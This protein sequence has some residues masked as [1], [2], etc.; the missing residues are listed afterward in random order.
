[1][2][3]TGCCPVFGDAATTLG[4]ARAQAGSAVRYRTMFRLATAEVHAVEVLA[5]CHDD[6]K[7]TDDRI[8]D[9]VCRQA[10]DWARTG[11]RPHITV[12]LSPRQ[13]GNPRFRDELR[14]RPEH[15]LLRPSGF[16]V[17]VAASALGSA[18]PGVHAAIRLL[19][20]DGLRI[21]I[22]LGAGDV[23]PSSLAVLR[24][25][26]VD[27]LR[28]T[29]SAGSGADVVGVIGSDELLS[30][31]DTQAQLDLL[32]RRHCTIG[33]G[34]RIGVPMSAADT[35]ALLRRSAVVMAGAA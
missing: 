1:M 10:A 30:G 22:G 23:S 14:G 29:R 8:L 33:R 7:D 2:T 27:E 35:T 11:I 12:R 31:I 17:E 34:F 3:G 21:S 16:T 25:L 20:H 26:P 28:I 24:H 13:L 19:H 15:V 4:G 5:S 9:E 6:D 18:D 32:V